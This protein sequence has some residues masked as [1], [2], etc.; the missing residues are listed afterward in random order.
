MSTHVNTLYNLEES[1]A[2]KA[3]WGPIVELIV[4]FM[5]RNKGIAPPQKKKILREWMS[6]KESGRENVSVSQTLPWTRRRRRGHPFNTTPSPSKCSVS[7]WTSLSEE[8]KAWSPQNIVFFK[9]KQNLAERRLRIVPRPSLT[10]RCFLGSVQSPNENRLF[11][12][13]AAK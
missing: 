7:A 1:K 9:K 3:S 5:L 2:K 6:E 8:I 4:W 13:P 12:V 10:Q 11:L